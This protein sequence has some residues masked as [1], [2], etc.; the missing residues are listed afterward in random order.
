LLEARSVTTPVF[1]WDGPYWGFLSG[2]Q[3]YDRYGRHVGWLEGAD[4]YQLSG[5]FMGEV[6][7]RHYVVRNTLREEP[8]HRAP[9]PAVPSLTPP[10]PLPNR[11][12]RDPMDDWS[13]ALPWPLSAPSPPRV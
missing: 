11:E 9:R 7:D 5:R 2:G 10:D 6:R 8:I 13:D 3:L 1:R 4:V 12:R